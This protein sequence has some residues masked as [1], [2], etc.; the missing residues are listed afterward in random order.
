MGEHAKYPNTPQTAADMNDILDALGQ[1]DM[2][3]WGFS[4]GSLIR[5]TYAGLFS[6]QSKRVIIMVS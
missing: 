1:K 5:Q 3:Y 6:E 2:I 4:Y